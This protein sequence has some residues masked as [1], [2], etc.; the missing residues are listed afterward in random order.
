MVE[1]MK[2]ANVPAA[3]SN[4][5]GTY[6]CNHLMYGVLYY[7]KREFPNAIGGFMHVPFLH[8]QVMNKKETP[9]LSK[10]DVVRGIE[11]S[12]EAIVDSLN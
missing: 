8:E 1:Y 2:A 7:I 11:A 6:V 4:S 5:A 9:S 10:D 3:V 12:I